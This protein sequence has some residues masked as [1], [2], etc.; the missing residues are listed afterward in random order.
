MDDLKIQNEIVEPRREPELDELK[1]RLVREH[2]E[3]ES[4]MLR[5]VEKDPWIRILLQEKAILVSYTCYK[6]TT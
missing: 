5:E 3:K 6:E 4:A 1:E 2:E